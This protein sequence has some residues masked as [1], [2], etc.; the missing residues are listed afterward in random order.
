MTFPDEP[1]IIEIADPA[2]CAAVC[3][4]IYA[5]RQLW[6]A[7]RL[8]GQPTF[9]TLG[10]VSYLDLRFRLRSV[11]EYLRA[12][13]SLWRWAGEPVR[14]IFERVRSALEHH[15]G[16]RVEYPAVLPTPGFHIFIGAAIPKTDCSRN[17]SDCGSSHFDLQYDEIPWDRWY[18]HVDFEN[19]ISLTLAL[20][21]PAAG[22]GLTFWESITLEGVRAASAKLGFSDIYQGYEKLSIPSLAN[23]TPCSTIPY[24]V[25]SMV[26]HN[27]HV[28]HQMAGIG[29]VSVAD[30]RITVQGHGVLADGAWRLFW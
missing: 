30:E 23:T 22:G 20:K 5:Q 6:R 26:L 13:G 16:A 17:V 25:G 24:A 18:T 21:L 14:T 4:E 12:A 10:A 11:D 3:R 27:S 15:L 28:L 2:L 7:W 1:T 9:Y 19:A 8:N 29:K